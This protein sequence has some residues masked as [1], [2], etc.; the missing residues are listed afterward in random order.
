MLSTGIG[1]KHFSGALTQ[2]SVSGVFIVCFNS[3]DQNNFKLLVSFVLFFVLIICFQ[4]EEQKQR[5][6]SQL[7]GATVHQLSQNPNTKNQ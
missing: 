3:C 1:C 5:M 2:V 7:G 4:G 6:F